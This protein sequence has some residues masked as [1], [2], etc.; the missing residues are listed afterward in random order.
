MSDIRDALSRILA[1]S[2]PNPALVVN[3]RYDVLQAN[4]AALRL[5]AFFAPAWRGKNNV[6]LMLFSP[7]GLR[8]A[9]ANWDE[10]AI[11]IVHRVRSELGASRA[12]D[13]DDEAI[14]EQAVAAARELRRSSAVTRP[15]AILIPVKL[16]RD[17]VALDLFTTIT[18]LGTPL[19]ITL[20]E[21]RIESLFPGSARDR[22]TLARITSP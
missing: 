15:P 6:A 8:L 22:D 11:H 14:L 3:R 1:A 18:T 4:D 2:E 17:G 13:A 7:D 16:R 21:L 10:V 5:L 19:D 9:V 20:Q 12:R